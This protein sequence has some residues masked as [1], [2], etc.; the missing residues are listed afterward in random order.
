MF[1]VQDLDLKSDHGAGETAQQLSERDLLV[2]DPGSVPPT[3]VKARSQ[4]Y[5]TAVLGTWMPSSDLHRH[6]CGAHTCI[7]TKQCIR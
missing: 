5:V 7:Q 6:A 3:H 2:K 1:H 4:K